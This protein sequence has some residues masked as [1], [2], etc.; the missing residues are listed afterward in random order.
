M[1]GE[2]FILL[3][4]TLFDQP[5]LGNNDTVLTL[6][7]WLPLTFRLSYHMIAMC[8]GELLFL[9]D[10]PLPISTINMFVDDIPPH[11]FR[12]GVFVQLSTIHYTVGEKPLTFL[13]LYNLVAES[14]DMTTGTRTPTAL[15]R[16]DKLLLTL[17]RLRT[18]PVYKTFSI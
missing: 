9:M 7:F 18:Y 13:Q 1:S 8:I 11:Q 15:N 3:L 16:R 2:R 17:L 10:D 14:I 12:R 6:S 5:M 4:I